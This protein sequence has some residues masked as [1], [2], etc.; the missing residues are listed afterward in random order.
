MYTKISEVSSQKIFF[1]CKSKYKIGSGFCSCRYCNISHNWYK[2]EIIY[3]IKN[4]L[5]HKKEERYQSILEVK[6]E[7]QKLKE[8]ENTKKCQNNS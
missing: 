7:I 1:G 5:Y 6:K 8:R 2:I 4:C 3:I